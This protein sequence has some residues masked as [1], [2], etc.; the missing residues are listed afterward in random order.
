MVLRYVFP[1][2]CGIIV[3]CSS[4]AAGSIRR[5][6]SRRTVRPRATSSKGRRCMPHIARHVTGPM[7]TH[8]HRQPRRGRFR[9]ATSDDDLKRLIATG[10]PSAGMPPTPLDAGDLTASWRHRSGLDVNAR[11]VSVAIGDASRFLHEAP[12]VAALHI[13]EH[14]REEQ[15]VL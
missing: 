2:L 6:G 14:R 4:R 5:A 7:A 10:I 11:A 1:A 3:G 13:Q 12:D 9:L 15:A 8:R